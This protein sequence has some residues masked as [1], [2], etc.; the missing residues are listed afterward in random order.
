M[1]VAVGPV[2]C[3]HVVEV[4]AGGELAPVFEDVGV[5]GGVAFSY[6]FF[7]AVELGCGV[8]LEWVAE[9]RGEIAFRVGP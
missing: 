7:E 6:W 8:V 4:V 9:P 2:L 1:D 5:A 3:A